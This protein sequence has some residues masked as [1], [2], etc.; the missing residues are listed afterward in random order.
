[1]AVLL[2]GV[3]Q[4]GN[5]YSGRFLAFL[6]SGSLV[7]KATIFSEIH[8][9]WLVPYV[10]YIPVEMDLSDLD[11]KVKWAME[12]DAEAKRIAT[13][14][15]RFAEQRLTRSQLNCYTYLLFLEFGR[16]VGAAQ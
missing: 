10:H 13:N 11:A 3:T 7:F 6:F 2:Y 14:A 1:M 16:L 4:D 5:T 9:D 8:N 12:H 15:Q